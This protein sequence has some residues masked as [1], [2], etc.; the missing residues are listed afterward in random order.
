MTTPTEDPDAVRAK[1]LARTPRWNLPARYWRSFHPSWTWRGRVFMTLL[2]LM[3]GAVGLAGI[4]AVLAL[5][6]G[7][8][9]ELV[10]WRVRATTRPECLQPTDA[11]RR[12]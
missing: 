4:A 3:F 8:V 9:T 12:R 11:G 10:D 1:L 7:S 2:L 5:L 6:V